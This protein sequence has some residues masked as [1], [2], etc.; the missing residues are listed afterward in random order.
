MPWPSC[1]VWAAERKKRG[2]L[3]RNPDTFDWEFSAF[4]AIVAAGV[5]IAIGGL[6]SATR[7]AGTM[8]YGVTEMNPGQGFT[9]NIVQSNP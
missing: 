6:L 3:D 7:V 9:A 1:L 8:S 5:A 4:G 2:A